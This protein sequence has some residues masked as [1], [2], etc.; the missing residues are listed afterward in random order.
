[1]KNKIKIFFKTL[2][3]IVNRPEMED[4]PGHLAFYFMMMLIPLLTLLGSIL[5][6]FELV[7]TSISQ[8]IYGH[9]P[10]SIADIVIS[11]SRQ[12]VSNLSL[13]IILV[14]TLIL[15]SNGTYSMIITS[16]SVYKVRPKGNVILAYIKDRTKA[17]IMLVVLIFIF[18]F[19]ILV[20]TL[21][22][23]IF[24]II[25]NIVTNENIVNNTYYILF[26]ILKYPVTFLFVFLSIKVL[27]VMAPDTKI[28]MKDTNL[29]AFFTSLTW[30]IVTLGYSYYIQ[31]F[32]SYETFYGGLSS[33]LFLML[34]IYLLSYM[35]VL[36]I[37]LNASKAR[38]ELQKI[39][40]NDK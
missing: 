16:N 23:V 8:V 35:F 29:G 36:G 13:W 24:K 39:E 25:G 15:A 22:N 28:K 21:G 10:S 37:A 38:G 5:T 2:Y 14:P 12:D 30:I 9:L 1:M 3:E 4:L 34:W 7:S 18:L 27:Y 33:L 32:S 17:F 26:K 20:P 11:V 19:L 31:Y 6:N 40:E